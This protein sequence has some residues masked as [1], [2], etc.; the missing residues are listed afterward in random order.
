[1][2]QVCV[3]AAA[4]V[5]YDADVKR[6]MPRDNHRS[7]QHMRQ[8]RTAVRHR[9]SVHSVADPDGRTVA[10]RFEGL[11]DNQPAHMAA[12]ILPRTTFPEPNM[13]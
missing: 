7:R 5:G 11:T 12:R 6:S 2:L 13:T 10:C 4:C 8:L 9:S 3:F 1:M